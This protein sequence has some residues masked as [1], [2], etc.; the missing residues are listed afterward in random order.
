MEILFEILFEVYFELMMLIVP[1]EKGTLLK[2]RLL[3][4]LVALIVFVGCLALFGWGILVVD[5]GNKMGWLAVLV[6]IVVSVAQI[7]AGFVLYM[8]RNGQLFLNEVE[9]LP[10]LWVGAFFYLKH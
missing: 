9:G 7:V 10:A 6:A 1:A 4:C 3:S 5:S 2:Y 8:K